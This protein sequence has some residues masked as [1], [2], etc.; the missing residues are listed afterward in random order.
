[1]TLNR[2]GFLL[3]GGFNPVNSHGEKLHEAACCGLRHGLFF[4]SE[5]DLFCKK[6]LTHG[7]CTEFREL[8]VSAGIGYA[9]LA[10]RSFSSYPYWSVFVIF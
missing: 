6:R 5:Q 10:I 1:M 2:V 8:G 9:V 4:R 7:E 3:F